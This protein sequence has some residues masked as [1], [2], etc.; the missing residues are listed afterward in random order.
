MSLAIT[1]ELFAGFDLY[2]FIE[3]DLGEITDAGREYGIPAP[4]VEA[5]Q[6]R[7]T[8]AA[9]RALD[10]EASEWKADQEVMAKRAERALVAAAERHAAAQAELDAARAALDPAI[11]AALDTGMTAY[12]AAK[13]TGL[14]QTTVA[15]VRKGE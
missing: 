2:Q 11:R 13:I 14:A 12:R 3:F 4:E 1:N 9:E 8:I 6:D 5:M 7:L 10:E 15:R